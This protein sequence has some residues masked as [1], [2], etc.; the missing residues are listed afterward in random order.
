[1]S[2][3]RPRP[4]IRAPAAAFRVSGRARQLAAFAVIGTANTGVFLVLYLL[5]RQ[6]FPPPVASVLAMVATTLGGTMATGRLAF[7][8]DG[9]IGTSHHLK[10]LLAT[11]LGMAIT[12]L[13]VAALGTG[14]PAEE[15]VVLV[16]A[17]AVAGGVRFA[18]FRGWVFA[19]SD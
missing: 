18:L 5:L 12:T 11:G 8:F 1:M 6:A 15:C 13:A 9:E 14:D 4:A 10:G 7:G 2:P 16:A 19:D 3:S 17:S